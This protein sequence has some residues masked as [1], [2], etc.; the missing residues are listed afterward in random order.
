MNGFLLIDKPEGLTSHGV[1]G[2]VRRITGIRR[3]G[4][5]GTLDPM[6]TGLLPICIGHAT[7][8]REYMLA[9]DKTYQ[10]LLILG[11]TSDT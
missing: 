8:M 7:R 1:V 2:R 9:D 5:T 11:Y 4:H 3:V 6:A 10:G